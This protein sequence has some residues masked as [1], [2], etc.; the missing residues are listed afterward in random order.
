MFPRKEIHAVGENDPEDHEVHTLKE[1]AANAPEQQGPYF[2]VT[3]AGGFSD[4]F[5]RPSW[6]ADAVTAY[7]TTPASKRAAP[8]YKA[9]IRWAIT[10]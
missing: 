1:Y 10:I 7:F 9:M 5:S 6:Q 4:Y 8:G 3:A 2:K